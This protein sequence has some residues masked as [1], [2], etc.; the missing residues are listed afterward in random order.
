MNEIE[1]EGA[2]SNPI[3]TLALVAG[4]S[5]IQRQGSKERG[6]GLLGSLLGLRGGVKIAAGEEVDPR[7]DYV[8]EV[9]PSSGRDSEYSSYYSTISSGETPSLPVRALLNKHSAK[10]GGAENGEGGGNRK[11][12]GEENV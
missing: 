4:V 2:A 8:N 7:F 9:Y 11:P 3:F 1:D 6:K 12:G 10:N 5:P